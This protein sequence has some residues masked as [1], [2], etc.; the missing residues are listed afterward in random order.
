M[1]GIAVNWSTIKSM[2]GSWVI[3]TAIVIV[4]LAGV[5][6]ALVGVRNAEIRTTTGLVSVFRFASLGLI[7]VG[8]QLGGNPDYL[9]PAITFA[10]IDFVLPFA[11]AVEMS[12]RRAARTPSAKA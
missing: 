12:H 4:A 11:L 6:G 1:T 8:T 2:F 9:G 10:L 7:I 5:L 3:L